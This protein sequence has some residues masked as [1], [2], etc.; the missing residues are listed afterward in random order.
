VFSIESVK[1]QRICVKL[2][3][4]VRKTAAETH[5]ML[6]EAYG[7][8]AWRQLTYE[9]FEHFK[10][11]RNST[12]DKHSGQPSTSRLEPVSA[13]VKNI[14]CGNCQLTVQE[15]AEEVGISISSCHT[16]LMEDLGMHQVSA[17]PV[18]RLLTDD[19]LKRANDNEYLSK[20]VIT[21]NEMWSHDSDV[22]TKQQSS[23][24]KRPLCLAQ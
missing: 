15:V 24:W 3:F 9:S 18:S 8:D 5:N 10:N 11:G 12:D 14:I 4:K 2:C 13:Q 7:N 20:T 21:S 22:E 17:K 6:H 1:E 23:Y 19:L 16:I